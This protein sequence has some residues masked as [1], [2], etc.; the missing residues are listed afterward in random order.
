ML[1]DTLLFCVLLPVW[2]RYAMVV[3][4]VVVVV[5]GTVRAPGR[6]Y[7]ECSSMYDVC[8]CATV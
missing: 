1:F 3:V 7:C 5:C 8:G 6:C 4:F 2:G